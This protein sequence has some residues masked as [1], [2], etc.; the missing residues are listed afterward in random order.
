MPY[1][2]SDDELIPYVLP[3]PGAWPARLNRV[4]M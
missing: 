2:C 4:E 3:E 1:E